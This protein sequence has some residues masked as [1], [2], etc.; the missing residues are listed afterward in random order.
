MTKEAATWDEA[1]ANARSE[2]A[3]TTILQR[4]RRAARCTYRQL[5]EGTGLSIAY[6]HDIEHGRRCAPGK[7]VCE[8]I[9]E[10]I[11]D[12]ADLRLRHRNELHAAL[13][14]AARREAMERAAARWER[15]DS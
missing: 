6:L 13:K 5:A 1:V 10:A 12:W 3:F 2:M 7:R 11:A 14:Q 9:A 4:A 15:D 8:N